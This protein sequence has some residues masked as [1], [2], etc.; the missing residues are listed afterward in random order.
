MRSDAVGGDGDRGWH[1]LVVICATTPLDG[2]RLADQ[3][4]AD[5]LSRYA[6][7]LYVDPPVTPLSLRREGRPVPPIGE[8]LVIRGRGFAHLTVVVPPGRERP[9]MKSVTLALTRRAMRR[10]VGDL[11][12]KSVAA[13]IVPSLNPLFGAL[14]ERTRVFYSKDDYLA[15]AELMGIASSRLRRREAKHPRDADLVVAASEELAEKWRRMGLTPLVLPNGC[16]PSHFAAADRLSTPADVHLP[17]PIAGFVGHLS[18]RIDVGML[19]AVADRGISL[20]LVGARQATLSHGRVERLVAR[21]NV[22]WVG[23]KDYGEL[24]GY[25][26]AMDVGLVPYTDTTFN[27]ASFPLKTLEYLAAGRPVVASDLPA[28]RWLDTPLVA[29]ASDAAAFATMTAEA[30]AGHR[31]E[32]DRARQV[33]RS[34]AAEHSWEARIRKLATALQLP[35]RETVDTVDTFAAAV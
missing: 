12:T 32:A 29:I 13:V 28:I 3:H 7:V 4:I 1:G 11:A 35:P 5:Q 16:D 33:R 18:E 14:G 25:V 2:N 22:Q 15:G 34:F 24:P 31:S 19:E 10:A 17:R 26:G 30:L 23:P 6:P 9:G 21:P 20:L 8:R 27:R